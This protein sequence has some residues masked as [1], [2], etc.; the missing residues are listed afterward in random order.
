MTFAALIVSFL[1]A[2]PPT[3]VAAGR[4]LRPDPPSYVAPDRTFD[5]IHTRLD[6]DVDVK[7]RT[8]AG[9]VTHTIRALRP[10]TRR[11]PLNCV[12]LTVEA[13]TLDGEPARYEYPVRGELATSWLESAAPKEASDMLVVHTDA[14]LPADRD[15]ELTIRYRGAPSE[16]LYFIQPEKGIPDKRPEV[17]SQGEGEDNRYWIPCH[18]YPNDTATFEGIF[19][20]DKGMYALSNGALVD[21]RDVGGKTEYHWKLETPHV[22]YLMMVAAGEYEV[23]EDTWKDVQLLYV[24][25][26]GTAKET[27]MRGYGLTPDMMEFFSTYIGIAYP[28]KKYAQVVVQD[29]IYGGME[30]TTATV[31]NMRTLYDDHLA[32]TQTQQGLVAHELAHQWWGDMVT[33][34]EW[35]QMWL[36]EGFATYFQSLYRE[37]HDG[38]DAFRYEIDGRHREIASNDDKEPLPVVVDFYN[39]KDSRNSANVYTKGASVLH[40]LRFLIG[41]DMFAASMRAYGE[42][43]KFN[44]VQ[45]SDFSRAVRETTGENLDWFFEQWVYLAGHPKL[46][47]TKSWDDETR[48]LRLTVKQTQKV[49]DL[50][51]LFRLPMDVEVTCAEKTETY[52]ILVDAESQEFHFSLPSKPLMVIVDKGGW[53]LKTLEFRKPV[54]ELVYQLRNGDTLARIAAARDLAE[55]KGDDRVAAALGEVAA[56]DAFWGLRREAALALGAL[57]NEPARALLVDALKAEDARVRL[58]ATEALGKLKTSPD[59]DQTLLGL[60]RKDYAY[61]VRAAAVASLVAMKSKQATKAC[62]EALGMTSDRELIRNAGLNGLVDLKATAEIDQVKALAGPGNP[63]EYR[64]TA[65]VGYAKLAKRLDSEKRRE[66]AAEFLCDMLDDWYLR[67]RTT[68]ISALGDLGDASAVKPLREVARDDSIESIREH[69]AKIASAIEAHREVVAESE[70]LQREI[71]ALSSKLESFRNDLRALKADVP[72][73]PAAS[74]S[75]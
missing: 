24:V 73:A 48:S 64:H 27:V 59:L 21:R 12:G 6:L 4:D 28:Y 74:G 66:Q 1:L 61:D 25:P 2:A 63:R 52:R 38:D 65:I 45:T 30:N 75:E 19:R 39:R 40:M 33:C 62:I 43:N 32:V 16:G 41:D 58:A 56:S 5:T 51:P 44:V 13:V 42:R 46:L 14:P 68:V 71:E 55:S 11:I 47:A 36:N 50:V 23:I 7:N 10:D 29:Y 26:P 31:M 37:H 17:W 57:G 34:N 22:S 69:A 49:G 54:E 67:T 9:S 8:I 20:V 70:N 72:V 53:T 60:L 15:T 35:S 3:V 18:D